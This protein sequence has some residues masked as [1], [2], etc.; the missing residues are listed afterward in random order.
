MLS[1]FGGGTVPVITVRVL[2]RFSILYIFRFCLDYFVLVMF[3]FVVLGLVSSV[4]RQEIGWEERISEM[5][6]FV[7]SRT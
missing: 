1:H 5:T 2:F 3:A 6:C 7:S 4:L